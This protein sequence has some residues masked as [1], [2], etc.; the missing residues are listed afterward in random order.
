M[1]QIINHDEIQEYIRYCRYIRRDLEL[2][3]SDINYIL[4]E[5]GKIHYAI[6]TTEVYAYTFPHVINNKGDFT[7]FPSDVEVDLRVIQQLVLEEIFENGEDKVVLLA[8]YALE[9]DALVHKIIENAFQEMVRETANVISEAEKF[10]NTEEYKDFVTLSHKLSDDMSEIGT[11]KGDKFI[12]SLRAYAPSLLILLS[13]EGLNPLKRIKELFALNKFTNINEL[14]EGFIVPST[15][16]EL[17]QG[18]IKE[19]SRRRNKERDM[20]SMLD[21]S[22]LSLLLETNKRLIKKKE[23]LLLVTRSG[24]MLQTTRSNSFEDSWN[25]LGGYPLRHPRYF[26]FKSLLKNKDQDDWIGFLEKQ[27]EAV[28]IFLDTMQ[29]LNISADEFNQEDLVKVNK[30]LIELEEKWIEFRTLEISYSK[31]IDKKE[32]NTTSF[33]TYDIE[34]IITLLRDSQSLRDFL[35]TRIETLQELIGDRHEYLGPYYRGLQLEQEK[36]ISPVFYA[37]EINNHYEITTKHKTYPYSFQLYTEVGKSIHGLFGPDKPIGWIE[38]L[39]ILK[40]G[41]KHYQEFERVLVFA[42]ILAVTNDWESAENYCKRALRDA[43]P[44][45]KSKTHEGYIFLST[46]IR[47]QHS[48]IS[49]YFEAIDHINKGIILKK[50]WKDDEKYIDYRFLKEKGTLYLEIN[51]LF[52]KS[53]KRELPSAKEGLKILD[54]AYKLAVNDS[55]TRSHILNNKLYYKVNKID[56]FDLPDIAESYSELEGYQILSNLNESNWEA[57]ILD[58]LAWSAYKIFGVS[59]S[60]IRKKIKDRFELALKQNLSV[61]EREDIYDHYKIFL[62]SLNR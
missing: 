56:E 58:T 32:I 55:T 2:L 62:Q 33:G 23:I 45:D 5:D 13:G 14:V 47:K 10:I 11:R 50:S 28:D 25:R 8:P 24:Y 31:I 20:S 61:K 21:G 39:D 12:S 59:K 19:L 30:E 26:Y 60:N 34:D 27:L 54:E 15:S 38:T 4:H 35:V 53:T 6:D 51:L 52:A 43:L 29:E 18:F 42:Y 16:S 17:I 36:N 46:C 40:D 1:E 49:R 7:I 9:I 3:I 22:A 37:K 57:S 44:E 48:S 41:L